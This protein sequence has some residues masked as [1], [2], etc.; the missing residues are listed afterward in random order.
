[1]TAQ[2]IDTQGDVWTLG[3]DG[4]MHTPET[5]AFPREHVEKKWGPLKPVENRE[6][7]DRD[8]VLEAALIAAGHTTLHGHRVAQM[9]AA[10]TAVTPLIQQQVAE[11]IAA[12]IEVRQRA[13]GRAVAHE[14]LA[15]A[16]KIAREIGGVE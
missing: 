1:M 2:W 9:Q 11:Q 5:A 7:S 8:P 16:A 15:L 13:A 12:A 10:I 6:V 4:L 14:A 3:D